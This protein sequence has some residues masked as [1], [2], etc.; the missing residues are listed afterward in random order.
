[1]LIVRAGDVILKECRR[2]ILLVRETPLHIGHLRHMERLCEMGAIIMPPMP[3]FNHRPQSIP[4]IIDHTIGKTLDLLGIEYNL[5]R[6]WCGLT[7][8]ESPFGSGQ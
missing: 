4:E 8:V 3:A 6:R 1:N 5:F 7:D 2:L